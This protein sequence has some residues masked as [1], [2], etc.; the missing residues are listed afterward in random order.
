MIY[1]YGVSVL[2][3]FLSRLIESRYIYLIIGFI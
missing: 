1:T 2:T 3:Y